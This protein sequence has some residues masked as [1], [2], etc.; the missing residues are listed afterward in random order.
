VALEL[1]KAVKLPLAAPSANRFM[2]LSPT[3]FEDLDPLIAEKAAVVLDGGPCPVGVESTI[4][5][6]AEGKLQLLR[7]GGLSLENIQAIAGEVVVT[8]SL[9][10]GNDKPLAPGMLA[11]HYAPR[12]PA[13]WDETNAFVPEAGTRAGLLCFTVPEDAARFHMVEALSP[14]GD[15]QEAAAKVFSTLAMLDTQGLD[16]IVLRRFPE[17]GLGRAINDRLRRASFPSASGGT[18]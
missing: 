5:A 8:A 14:K 3:R 10:E 7:P 13:V 11:R 18:P 6:Y 15:L 12:T 9:K 4:V 1:L 17:R 2:S 16:Q